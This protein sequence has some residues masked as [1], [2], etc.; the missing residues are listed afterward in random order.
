MPCATLS[1]RKPRT[2][3]DAIC[4]AQTWAVTRAYLVGAN[5][6]C[7]SD[8]YIVVNN[9]YSYLFTHSFNS[10]ARPTA[11]AEHPVSVHLHN[12]GV[13]R[14][15]RHSKARVAPKPACLP[16][17]PLF[18]YVGRICAMTCHLPRAK[19]ATRRR[20]PIRQKKRQGKP[21]H[22]PSRQTRVSTD[23]ACVSSLGYETR[24]SPRPK[25]STKV[26]CRKLPAQPNQ[27][28]FGYQSIT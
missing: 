28:N 23:A 15:V 1:E 26:Q 9:S 18:L 20:Q 22:P 13:I 5:S 19:K 12:G 17:W 27:P 3:S 11:F 4:D 7:N 24:N 25:T 2:V 8:Q 6:D 21:R 10:I 16:N 14:W